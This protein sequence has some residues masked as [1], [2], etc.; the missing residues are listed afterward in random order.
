MKRFLIVKTSALGDIIHAFPVVSYLRHHYPD[1]QIDWVVE[2]PF[3]DLVRAH[4]QVNRVLCVSTKVWRRSFWKAATLKEVR[5]FVQQLRQVHYNAAFDLQGNIKSG[6]ILSRVSSDVKVGFARSNVPEWPNLLFTTCKVAIPQSDNVREDYLQL[7]ARFI[8][9]PLEDSKQSLTLRT[10]PQQQ[11]T[12]E[13]WLAHPA[14]Q[15]GR[16]IMVCPGS[17]WKNKQMTPEALARFLQ[18]LAENEKCAFLFM[19]GSSEEK[20][21]AEALQKKFPDTA[22]VVDRIPLPAMHALMQRCD[23]V[24]AM[25]SLPLHLAGTTQTPTFA[26]FGP[27]S[28]KKY[29]PP[30]PTHGFYQGSCPYGRTFV[31]RCPVLRTC[32]TGACL[33]NPIGDAVFATFL[34]WQHSSQ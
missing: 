29:N 23:L 33:R 32:P 17:A 10:T 7:V 14:L 22:C 5:A 15:S 12:V 31:K 34:A 9:N 18:L 26:L 16:K 3:A 24:I 25:D 21:V 2:A 13:K 20:Q 27:S 1:A 28:A 6:L 30:G 8:G 4:P 11:E 19:W